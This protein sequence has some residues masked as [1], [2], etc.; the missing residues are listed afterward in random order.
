MSEKKL[1]GL[2]YSV[3]DLAGVIEGHTI[4][5]TFNNSVSLAQH[6]EKLG[7]NRYWL[8]EH[9]NM[10][11]VASSA[12]SVLIGHI[13]GHTKTIRVGSGGIMLPN[14]TPLIIAEQFGTLATIYPNR[15]DLG[16]G[17]APGTDQLT[18]FE[19]R[20]ERFHSS[21]N[22]P[23]DVR[24]LQQ[25]LGD[26]NYDSRVRA[27]PGE[28]TNV[29]IWILGSSTESAHLAA[30]YGLPYAFA[31]HFAPTHFFE[32]I[33]IYRQNFRPS[34]V[35]Q[36]P[37]VLSCVNVVAA[38][39]DEEAERLSTSLK[40]LFMGIVTNKRR[41][42][43]PPVDSMEGIWSDIEE[44]AVEQMLDF[45]FIA[46]PEKL[47]EQLQSFLKHTQ[48]DELMVTSHIYDHQARLRSYEIVAEVLR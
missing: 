19:I 25:Y 6:A 36:K 10:I 4:A 9:H 11:S 18:A 27:I 16:L 45:T 46:G 1:S 5:D 3:L 20:G 30:S 21:Q 39:T 48:V 13:A 17:R 23:Q 40:M 44:A 37:Y 22:F 34:E 32:A 15:I 28:G 2:P 42:L 24:K 47:K 31:S 35:L 43:Q 41:L 8:A 14:H 33:Q 38:D 7:Y 26:D 29:P 12:T